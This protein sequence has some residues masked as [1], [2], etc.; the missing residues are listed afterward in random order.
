MFSSALASR[1]QE[2]AVNTSMQ[3]Y[4]MNYFSPKQ[5]TT[6]FSSGV[7][8]PPINSCHDPQDL[9]REWRGAWPLGWK[10]PD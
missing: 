6:L 2:L 9:S 4:V 5:N 8:L 7:L 1:F 10:P 3:F